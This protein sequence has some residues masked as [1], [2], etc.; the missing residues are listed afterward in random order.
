[1]TTTTRSPRCSARHG[2]A[3]IAGYRV[4]L[5]QAPGAAEFLA[6]AEHKT[7][8]RYDAPGLYGDALAEAKAIRAEGGWAVVDPAYSCGCIGRG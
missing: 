3:T 6:P 8:A 7:V 1:V 4:R 5:T 2:L